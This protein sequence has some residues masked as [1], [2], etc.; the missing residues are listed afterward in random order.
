MWK[1]AAKHIWEA[2]RGNVYF[3]LITLGGGAVVTGISR[4]IHY[5][6]G[7][8]QT[9]LKGTFILWMLVSCFLLLT[10]VAARREARPR[11]VIVERKPDESA[12]LSTMPNLLRSPSP[13]L[14]LPVDL[15][16]EIL[17]IYF[18]TP[19]G[20]MQIGETY[21]VAKVS[22]V[23][24]GPDEVTITRVRLEIVVGAF[25][26]IAEIT[27]VPAAWQVKR[28]KQALFGYTYDLTPIAP[29]LDANLTYPKG[30]PRIGWLAFKFYNLSGL[31]FP[32]AEFR[33][34]LIDSL[35]GEHCVVRE[36]MAY[37]R[38]GEIVTVA[39]TPATPSPNP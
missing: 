26:Q 8:P 30:I 12:S 19:E 6:R 29:D 7:T 28:R 9:D 13:K 34:R 38:L 5:V 18:Y 4:L 31:E 16:G 27:D 3:W 25:R 23:N 10:W 21:I 36:P 24:H 15:K 37:E 2:I 22:I 11:G 39:S 33:L 1:A 32:N 14:P 35:N 20:W 17:E